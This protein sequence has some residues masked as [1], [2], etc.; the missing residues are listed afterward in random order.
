MGQERR[1]RVNPI[2][3]SGGTVAALWRALPVPGRIVTVVVGGLVLIYLW[4]VL[5][6][7]MVL[8]ALGVGIVT[9]IKWFVSKP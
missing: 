3:K 4:Q 6:G 9:I 2:Q 5:I 8:A 7:L 1:Q